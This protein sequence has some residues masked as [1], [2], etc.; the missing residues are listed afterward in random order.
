MASEVVLTNKMIIIFLCVVWYTIDRSLCKITSRG[1]KRHIGWGN[2]VANGALHTGPGTGPWIRIRC[3]SGIR[4]QIPL[5][6]HTVSIRIGGLNVT[7]YRA[8]FASHH[9]R[10]HHVGFLFTCE[11]CEGVG[12]STK[13]HN[14]L[15]SSFHITKL[16]AS[17]KNISTHT[18]MNFQTLPRSESKVLAFFVVF[19][20]T[21]LCKRQP[22]NFGKSCARR[23][24]PRRRANPLHRRNRNFWLSTCQVFGT[25]EWPDLGIT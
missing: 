1:D 18:P 10:D 19:L 20:H 17:D 16:Q 6:L 24:L 21:A 14:F 7:S 23:C 3:W 5:C 8:N 22:R 4:I 2:T 15:F 9:T 13:C 12:K 25:N 11:E